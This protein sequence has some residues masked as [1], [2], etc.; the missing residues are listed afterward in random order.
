MKDSV[1]QNEYP[2]SRYA[3]VDPSEHHGAWLGFIS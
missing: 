1:A 3:I 2:K